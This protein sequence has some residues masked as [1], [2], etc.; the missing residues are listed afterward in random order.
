MAKLKICEW[1]SLDENLVQIRL[2][3]LK[4]ILPVAISYGLEQKEQ[5]TKHLI[6]YDTGEKIDHQPHLSKF[7]EIF[8]TQNELFPDSDVLLFE[9]NVGFVDFSSDL[10]TQFEDIIQGRKESAN[11]SEWFKNLQLFFKFLI[12]RRIY[13]VEQWF[14]ENISNFPQ[15]NSEVVIGKYALEKEIDKLTHFWTLC[16]LSCQDCGLRCLKNHG[17]T[18]NHDCKTNHECHFS[19]QFVEAHSSF[20]PTCSY[21]AGHDGKHACNKASHLCGKPCKLIDKCNCQKKC[22][23]D[24]GHDGGLEDDEHMCQSNR[25]NCGE[26]CSLFTSTKKGDYESF[27]LL[28]NS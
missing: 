21:K 12:E 6:I 1:G 20:I 7:A 5:E 9:E 16:G 19:C 18:D 15:D 10:R 2:S 27:N 24:I 22:S 4:R 23:K 25:H 26:P 14:S 11:D 3:T 17:H 28:T 13:R 8:N